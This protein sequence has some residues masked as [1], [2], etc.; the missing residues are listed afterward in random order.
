MISHID[1]FSKME[2]LVM[3][4]NPEKFATP[5]DMLVDIFTRD[6]FVGRYSL[7][8]PLYI[9]RVSNKKAKVKSL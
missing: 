6:T 4:L 3:S 1:T 9:R 7:V 8:A 2:E 5:E